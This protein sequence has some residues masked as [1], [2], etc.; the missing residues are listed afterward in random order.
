[1]RTAC[2]PL[3][4]AWRGERLRAPFRG[5]RLHRARRQPRRPS[6]RRRRQLRGAH[7]GRPPRRATGGRLRRAAR[8]VGL[9]GLP[10]A[11]AVVHWRRRRSRHAATPA[12]SGPAPR[13]W[14]DASA[15]PRMRLGT[16]VVTGSAGR[17]PALAS[18]RPA[19]PEDPRQVGPAPDTPR[20]MVRRSA[21]GDLA[22]ITTARGAGLNPWLALLGRR[23][24]RWF[25]DEGGF[26]DDRV[27]RA[28]PRYVERVAE[29]VGDDVAGWFP[30]IDPPRWPRRP[31]PGATTRSWSLASGP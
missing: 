6:V 31:S 2:A 23:L 17:Y 16:F 19:G 5:R 15:P 30:M 28:W 27:A 22:S 11:G 20:P 29:H 13:T 9:A 24:P 7:A 18:A 14:P 21:G 12:S 4:S 10:P 1:M 3:P 26:A 25:E 8:T